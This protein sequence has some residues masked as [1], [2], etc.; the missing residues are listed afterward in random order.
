MGIDINDFNNGVALPTTFHQSLH[1]NDY[2]DMVNA[3]AASWRTKADAIA[4]LET[5]AENL[6]KKSGKLK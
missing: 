4:G 2:Y 1:T 5:I 6:M 3:A